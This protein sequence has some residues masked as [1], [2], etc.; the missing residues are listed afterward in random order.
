[1]T[2]RMF[3]F[4]ACILLTAAPAR[5][6]DARGGQ[7][8][9]FNG[10]SSFTK[11][12]GATTRQLVF[13]SPVILAQIKYNELVVSWDAD[14][15]DGAWIKFEAR[16]L[17]SGRE[18]KYYTMSLWSSNPARFP[19]ECVLNQKDDDADVKTDTLILSRPTERLQVRVTM[20][21][22]EPEMPR[23]KFLGI[24]LL[25]TTAKL[26]PL[27]PNN[28]AWGKALPVPERCQL[29]YTN[30]K[31]LCSPTTVSMIMT[32]WSQKLHRPELNRD[33]PDVVAAIYDAAWKGTGNWP[34][35][36]AYPGSYKGMRS[37]VARLSD[38]SEVED[39]VAAGVPVGLSVCSDRLNARGPGP[40][41]HL[42]TCIGFTEDGD[43]IINDPG[44]SNPT[45]RVYPRKRVIYA[46][47]YSK[48]TVYLI[49]PEDAEIP[50]DRFGHWQSWT[51]RNRIR[52]E[53]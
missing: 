29:N 51:S 50:K 53:R 7:F 19:R 15:P 13:T 31:V 4:V 52:T 22:A 11:E 14:T 39:W 34:F 45:R 1:M 33:V 2:N 44:K 49:Y 8:L 43:P 40:N 32:Y 48:N 46:W 3:G 25:D 6:F 27:P 5:A 36:T 12:P 21:S 17:Y 24:A 35:N 18:T 10:L 28:L 9:G 38:F 47:A 41:G 37:Y 16:A 30:G 20:G 42:I 26:E 23:V